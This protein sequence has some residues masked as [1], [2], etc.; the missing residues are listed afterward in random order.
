MLTQKIWQMAQIGA[1]WVL[2]FLLI[3]SVISIAL[4]IER[5]L[6]FWRMTL[7]LETTRQLLRKSL[8]R[9]GPKHALTR[10]QDTPHVQTQILYHALEVAHEGADAAEERAT[11]SRISQKYQLERGLV[12][13]GTLGNNAPFIGL[14]GTVLGIINAFRD[15][16]GSQLQLA[17]GK[18]MGS[19]SE[20]LVATA[21]GL[22]VALPA[23]AAFNFFQ[24]RVKGLLTQADVLLHDLLAFLRRQPHP[25]SAH[26]H[27]NDDISADPL[28]SLHA[29]QQGRQQEQHD[30]HT[31]PTETTG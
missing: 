10:F 14:F 20:A 1:E 16:S 4:M 15:L 18:I 23:V 6:Y 2:Y 11:G 29:T 5:A 24:R 19:I 25:E 12:F 3:L 21:V 9:G 17:S 13:L 27:P 22:L 26:L 8:E 31:Q 28:A 7:D 30:T